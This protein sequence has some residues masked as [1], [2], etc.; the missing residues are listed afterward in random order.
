VLDVADQTLPCLLRLVRLDRLA[1]VIRGLT[2]AFGDH[3]LPSP[4]EDF[5]YRLERGQPGVSW[6]R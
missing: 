3:C 4:A 5:R 1:E 6:F 2:A